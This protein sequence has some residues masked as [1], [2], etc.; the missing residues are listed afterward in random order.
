AGAYL[1]AD[2]LTE[3]PLFRRVCEETLDWA[4]RELRQDEGGFASCL[5]A[6]SEGVEGK[7][8]VWTPSEIRSALSPELAEAAIA[9]YGVTEGGNFEGG[10][11]VLTR[12]TGDPAA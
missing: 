3:E 1:H 5:D 4:V 10:T 12:V 2:Q 6:D 7:F 8:Y 11:T 9:H